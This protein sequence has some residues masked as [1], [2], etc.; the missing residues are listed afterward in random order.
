MFVQSP[1]ALK[2]AGDDVVEIWYNNCIALGVFENRQAL[3][4]YKD[5]SWT[6]DVNVSFNNFKIPLQEHQA[7]GIIAGDIGNYF[8]CQVIEHI[9]TD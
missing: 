1:D 6:L 3:R 5:G 2:Y 8:N 4:K 9:K 7:R